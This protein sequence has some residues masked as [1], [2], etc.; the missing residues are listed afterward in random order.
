MIHRDVMGSMMLRDVHTHEWYNTTD[1]AKQTHE[2][3]KRVHVRQ[4][5]SATGILSEFFCGASAV[6]REDTTNHNLQALHP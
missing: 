2:S 1:D 3:E 5:L 6:G 4:G